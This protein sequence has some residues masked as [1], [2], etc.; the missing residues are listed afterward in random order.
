[1][2]KKIELEYSVPSSPKVLFKRLSTVDG[3][4][5][6]F[7][8]KVDSK[9]DIYTFAW[10]GEEQQA[11]LVEVVKDESITFQWLEDEDEDYFFKFCM[12]ID[13]MTN[14]V[15]LIITDFVD[16]DDEDDSIELWD[17]QIDELLKTLGLS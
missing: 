15:A 17:K 3:L 12:E 13:P 1:M 8:D 9:D 7:A 4:A 2:K 16:E 14:E 6:W 11:R 10:E 5:E